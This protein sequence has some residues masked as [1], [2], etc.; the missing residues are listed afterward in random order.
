MNHT[1]EVFMRGAGTGVLIFWII[2][3]G[4]LIAGM[5]REKS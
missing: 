1:C 4:A 3:V 2:V 5:Y